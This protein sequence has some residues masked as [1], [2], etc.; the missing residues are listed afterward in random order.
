MDHFSKS[1]LQEGTLANLTWQFSLNNLTLNRLVLLFDRTPFAE[2]RPLGKL[3]QFGFQNQFLIH[4]NPNQTLIAELH[5]LPV[6]SRIH[7]KILL[8]NFKVLHGLSPKYLSDLISMQQPLSY[9]LRHNDNGRFLERPSTKTKKTMGQRTFQVAAP[10][11][12]NKLPRCARDTTN[13]KSFNTLIKTFL[14][15]ESFQL[16]KYIFIYIYL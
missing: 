2:A 12:W 14:F 16:S 4:W 1:K 11:L 5:W 13:L 3:V 15:Q 9:N 6:R 10:F 7:Y 8:T